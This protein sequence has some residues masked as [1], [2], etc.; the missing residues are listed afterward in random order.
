[1]SI[2][3]K[4]HQLAD[5]EKD[6]EKNFRHKIRIAHIDGQ[7]F[8]GSATQLI[9][10]FDVMLGTKILIITYDAD[11]LL[12]ISAIFALEDI[13]ERLNSQHIRILLVVGSEPVLNQLRE[14]KIVAQIG[15]HH[16]FAEEMKAIEFAQKAIKRSK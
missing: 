13:I 2:E 11:D 10:K 8:F 6:I 5:R 9:S 15:V 3:K 16:V 4:E 7:F 14:H 12:D 1:M